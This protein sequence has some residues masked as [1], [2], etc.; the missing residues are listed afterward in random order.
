M[1]DAGDQ[2]TTSRSA[3]RL[4]TDWLAGPGVVH[5]YVN[6]YLRV[7]S[8]KDTDLENTKLSPS[9]LLQKYDKTY[10]CVRSQDLPERPKN[11][12]E[13]LIGEY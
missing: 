7:K 2:L 10:K 9:N 4:A 8:F 13:T 6:P 5:Q 11:N 3:I 12:R 1:H